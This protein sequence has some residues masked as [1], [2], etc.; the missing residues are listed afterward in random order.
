MLANA[1]DPPVFPKVSQI[2]FGQSC[3]SLPPTT[4]RLLT[5]QVKSHFAPGMKYTGHILEQSSNSQDCPKTSSSLDALLSNGTARGINIARAVW[6]W[7]RKKMYVLQKKKA[8]SGSWE[9]HNQKH[10]HSDG[11]KRPNTHLNATWRGFREI[12]P[13]S[14]LL[15]GMQNRV[16]L[17]AQKGGQ[18]EGRPL[19]ASQSWQGR[20]T[21]KAILWLI[22]GYCDFILWHKA[23]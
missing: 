20:G 12:H 21:L 18:E 1:L 7:S 3:L 15:G 19:P 6:R 16:R 23:Y 4:Q 14:C 17:P 11:F 10:T 8:G 9:P 2:I 22:L 13:L 5:L